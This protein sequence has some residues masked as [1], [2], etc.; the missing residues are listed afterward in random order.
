MPV[1]A[2]EKQRAHRLW[3]SLFGTTFN[4]CKPIR[5]LPSLIH[6]HHAAVL[7]FWTHYPRPR[8][9]CELSKGLSF[10]VLCYLV[11]SAA[12]HLHLHIS[13]SF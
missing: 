5:F 11:P 9:A 8:I 6:H 4:P 7:V 12:L 1:E 10:K 2:H 3:L 13:V